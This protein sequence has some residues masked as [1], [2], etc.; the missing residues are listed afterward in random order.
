MNDLK[1]EELIVDNNYEI[2]FVKDGEYIIKRK[3]KDRPLKIGID[4][5]GYQVITLNN[6]KCF[7]HRVIATQYL[8]NPDELP[9]ID[10]IDNDKTN[11]KLTN[12]RW[13]TVSENN[14]NKSSSGGIDY[15][16]VD[17]ISDDA[18]V[19]TDYGKHQFEFYYFDDNKFYYYN[20]VRYRE[21]HVNTQ[22]GG[23][24]YVQ[25][26]NT[27][28]KRVKIYLNKFKKLYDLI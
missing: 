3:D 28:N 23:A 6:K 9:Q 21:L 20:G 2:A 19:L 1:F 22:K 14:R 24:L 5:D 7:F 18:I 8:P 17:E 12:L 16:Y 27:E 11:N 25:V 4:K 26:W 15:V 10:H 13:C